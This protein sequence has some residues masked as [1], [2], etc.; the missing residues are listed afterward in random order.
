MLTLK[1]SCKT[2]RQNS[3]VFQVF[4]FPTFNGNYFCKHHTCIYYVAFPRVVLYLCSA[5]LSRYGES[6]NQRPCHAYSW[7]LCSI[8]QSCFI[9]SWAGLVSSL[10]LYETFNLMD[11]LHELSLLFLILWLFLISM[12][13]FL[14]LCH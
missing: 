3:S 5:F 2:N 7:V 12:L 6:N 10:Q 8:T 11:F 4:F 1:M 14:A 13:L 9:C